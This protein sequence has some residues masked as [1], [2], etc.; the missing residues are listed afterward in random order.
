MNTMEA[1]M[2]VEMGCCSEE[3]YIASMQHLIDTGVVWR[4]QGSYGRRA[5]EMIEAGVCAAPEWS[6]G[7]VK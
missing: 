5:V 6:Q 4:L 1:I 7:D 3:E 2:N